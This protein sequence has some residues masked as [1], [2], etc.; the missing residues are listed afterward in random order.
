MA[1]I[2]ALKKENENKQKRGYSKRSKKTQKRR[3][4]VCIDLESKGFLALDKYVSLKGVP[5]KHNK[6]TPEPDKIALREESEEGS[7]E[8]IV[9]HQD[10][11]AYS[12]VSDISEV[13]YEGC[14]PG[15]L[16]NPRPR[17]TH[18]MCMESKESSGDH[19]NDDTDSVGNDGRQHRSEDNTG[20]EDEMETLNAANKSLED[21]RQKAVLAHENIS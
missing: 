16:H 6:L 9:L 8:E 18:N 20:I 14:L 4:Q 7:E 3:N 13:E 10:T 12:S 5:V 19:D 15:K 11:C 17:L 21:I 2:A 1:Q